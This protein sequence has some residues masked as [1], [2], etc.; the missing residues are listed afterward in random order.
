MMDSSKP[1]KPTRKI[2]EGHLQAMAR[3]GLKEL[4]AAM[5]TGSNVA[6]EAEIGTFGSPGQGEIAADRRPDQPPSILDAHAAAARARARDGRDGPE[7]T[8]PEITRE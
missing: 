4:Q 5:Y 7:R 3:Q 8:A 2:G 6:R 1:A